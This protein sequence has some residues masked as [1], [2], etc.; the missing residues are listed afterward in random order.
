MIGSVGLEP[1]SVRAFEVANEN[2]ITACLIRGRRGVRAG[3]AGRE[4]GA[5]ASARRV[6]AAAGT[7]PCGLLRPLVTRRMRNAERPH[8]HAGAPAIA[9]ARLVATSNA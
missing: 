3:V 9:D 8:G 6:G 5:N 7:G 2:A 4:C 1:C